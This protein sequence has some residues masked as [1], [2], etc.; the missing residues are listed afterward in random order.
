M[1]EI[2]ENG[3]FENTRNKDTPWS[4]VPVLEK[5]REKLAP[6]SFEV[7]DGIPYFSYQCVRDFSRMFEDIDNA[8]LRDD[9]VITVGFPRS[10][11][12]WTFEVLTMIQQ[13]STDF[14]KDYYYRRVM[15][16]IGDT[17]TEKLSSFPSPRILALH[18]R[19]SRLPKKTVEK[20]VKVVYILRNPKDVLVSWYRLSYAA[21]LPENGFRGTWEEFYELQ[22]TG[23]HPWGTWFDHVLAAEQ[24]LQDNPDC[25]CFVLQ[26]EKMKENAV[27]VI[28]Q[29]CHFLGQPEA[30]AEDIAQRTNFRAMAEGMREKHENQV[31]SLLKEGEAFLVKGEIGGWKRYFTVDQNERFNSMFEEKMRGCKLADSVR[32]YLN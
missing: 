28:K 7:F 6:L 30:K 5:A 1:A 10:G 15:E 32:P 27:D 20:K 21:K 11:N 16:C 23:E 2:Q 4:N 18:T 26:Y 8:E 29:L 24:Y 12:H 9:D 19:M 14:A 31:K 13:Q 3:N 17:I 25:R 22:L